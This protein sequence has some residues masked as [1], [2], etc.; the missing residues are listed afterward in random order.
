[1][2]KTIELK[3]SGEDV[4]DWINEL[5]LILADLK[6]LQDNVPLQM[7]LAF[8]YAGLPEEY[9]PLVKLLV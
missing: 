6:T 4:L 9:Q 2:L 8:M 3:Q 1:M 7:E 5:N